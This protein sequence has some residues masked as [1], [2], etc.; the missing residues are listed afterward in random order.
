MV[1]SYTPNKAIQKPARG[2]Y[3]D[4]WDTP[5]NA[6]WDIIDK[7][8]GGTTSLNVTSVSGT[9]AL[10]ATQYQ[11]LILNITGTL[12]ANVTYQVPSTVG[13]QWIV[14]NGT[15]GAYTLT[16]SSGGAGTSV[17]VPQG[18]ST[19]VVS[20]GTNITRADTTPVTAA[21]S[22]TQIQYNASGVLGA[23]SNLTFDGVTV[24]VVGDVTVGNVTLASPS[25]S[26][27]GTT[28]TVTA[29]NNLSAGKTVVL[30]GWTGGTGTFN[31][32]WTVATAT[33]TSFTITSGAVSGSPTGGTVTA[34]GSLNV[35]ST[36]VLSKTLGVTGAITG[37][38]TI[39][40]T[41]LIPSG[42]S[43]PA[44][45]VYLPAAN[46]VGVA[47]NTTERLRI[48]STGAWGLAGANYGTSGQV[49]TSNGTGTSPTW[50][51][52]SAGGGT[53]IA[54]GTLSGTSL[55]ITNI[56]ATYAYI[57]LQIFG[58]SFTATATP[59]LQ[60][61]TNNGSSYD[62]TITNYRGIRTTSAGSTAMSQASM[63]EAASMASN[64]T[65][66]ITIRIA[67]Y[68]GGVYAQFTVNMMDTSGSNA[69]L[70]S[71]VYKSTSAINALQFA[72]GTFDAGT[73]ALYG[74]S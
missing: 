45:G 66:N 40:G 25:V 64:E 9:V 33:S 34:L 46:T 12:T 47:T 4:T 7:A 22:N 18:Y 13:G 41:A 30:A 56:P 24:N 43:V 35:A 44:N 58:V 62:S 1:S 38:S 6:D 37:S 10:T 65:F 70:V 29:A 74:Y 32:T 42:S 69:S 71:G 36:A 14:K 49:L 48:D 61:S 63:I 39:T 2:D 31:G 27:S 50:N 19:V 68:Q 8:F 57:V 52:I 55:S 54:S 20:D 26:G 72:G 51:S 73:Y 15:T 28:I 16:I 17:V 3:V 60:A 53:S 23:S 11:A 21:G 5:V 59:T 67:P